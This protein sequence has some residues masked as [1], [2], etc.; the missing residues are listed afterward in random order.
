[1]KFSIEKQELSDLC[2]LVYRAA[3]SKNSIPVLS[4][5]LLELEPE[6]GLTLTA[7]DMEIGTK[8]STNNIDL[9]AP[10]KVLVNASYLNSF[11]KSLPNTR[12]NI[13]YDEQTAKLNVMYG[14]SAGFI[15]TYRDY[16]YPDLLLEEPYASF[17]IPRNILKEALKKTSFAAALN[18]FRQV[19]T[20]ILFDFSDDNFLKVVA[21][22]TH[23][24]AYYRYEMK[25]R[26]GDPNSFIL[27]LR[28][29][30][31]L[32]RVL[33]DN[34]GPVNIMLQEKNV[35]FAWDNILLLS[36][37]I[38]GP[39]PVYDNVIPSNFI[40]QI[41]MKADVMA[42]I[43]ER[44]RTMPRDENLK[45]QFVQLSL[46]QGEASFYAYSE[47]MGEL[48]EKVDDISIEVEDEFKITFNTSYLL[49]AVRILQ[50][51]GNEVE[52]RFSG[53]FSSALI[54]NPKNDNYLYVLVPLRTGN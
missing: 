8:A 18:H 1:M 15:N 25:N 26:P 42:E 48:N 16:E 12:L 54:K 45:I 13:E 7:T 32:L 22:D 6:K 51:E 36:R 35:V 5:I 49:D 37:L 4:G 24:L 9:I 2:N 43:L 39:Y 17:T 23:R 28:T 11:I 52:I 41:R 20:G 29:A 14:R 50:N 44:A 3:S 40:N 21:S 31:E 53:P 33:D 27:P 10:G 38:N 47:L 34:E 19:F 46:N 30:H